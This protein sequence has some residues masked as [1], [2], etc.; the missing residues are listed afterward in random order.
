MQIHDW[1]NALATNPADFKANFIKK[2]S[3]GSVTEGKI[4]D[5]I[6]IIGRS[7]LNQLE[8]YLP[9]PV[10]EMLK[11][12]LKM[13]SIRFEKIV[14]TALKDSVEHT[15]LDL[16]GLG[17]L[18]KISILEGSK[19][20]EKAIKEMAKYLLSL[21]MP[22]H[23]SLCW[24]CDLIEPIKLCM[25]NYR[26][27]LIN[28]VTSLFQLTLLQ[29]NRQPFR[30]TLKQ[31]QILSRIPAIKGHGIVISFIQLLSA[32]SVNSEEGA[33]IE[34]E[35]KTNL[36][37]NKLLVPE[38]KKT[39]NK[40]CN[41]SF[42]NF[43]VNHT[44]FIL[45][46]HR[47][48]ILPLTSIKE[49][50]AK[51]F[52][53]S[54][55]DQQHA[56]FYIDYLDCLIIKEKQNFPFKKA[57]AL[58][59]SLVSNRTTFLYS[60]LHA[61]LHFFHCLAKFPFEKED[62]PAIFESIHA[63]ETKEREDYDTWI[64][65]KISRKPFQFNSKFISYVK[66]KGFPL[67]EIGRNILK[68]CMTVYKANSDNIPFIS[69]KEQIEFSQN[70]KEIFGIEEP[71]EIAID[72]LLFQSTTPAA[73][74]IFNDLV[75]I[76]LKI[77]TEYLDTLAIPSELYH[78][79]TEKSSSLLEAIETNS[80]N[81][82]N[83]NEER[84][85]YYP[86]RMI[87]FSSL[88]HFAV[89]PRQFSFFSNLM[90][91]EIIREKFRFKSGE[92]LQN[93]LEL[94]NRGLPDGPARF[95]YWDIDSSGRACFNVSL[96]NSLRRPESACIFRIPLLVSLEKMWLP[97]FLML[98]ANFID[99]FGNESLTEE[100]EGK[101]KEI[102]PNRFTPP[103][104]CLLMEGA[105]FEI[106]D[107]FLSHF[108]HLEKLWKDNE[109]LFYDT[110]LL[111]VK[112][113]LY[114]FIQSFRSAYKKCFYLVLSQNSLKS[115]I[116]FSKNEHIRILNLGQKQDLEMINL[117]FNQIYQKMSEMGWIALDF[118]FKEMLGK[119]IFFVRI[120]RP[121]HEGLI[122]I[123][124]EIYDENLSKGITVFYE[125]FKDVQH[126]L[127]LMHWQLKVVGFKDLV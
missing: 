25:D 74:T 51:L 18:Y 95:C 61:S 126:F 48:S 104:E 76:R 49:E 80:S 31:E 114:L 53:Q 50:L 79:L 11:E 45:F 9:A 19:I 14:M 15:P 52:S 35:L 65:E 30:L 115:E 94:I 101:V 4:K 60:F 24:K 63:L 105:A 54:I 125:S 5:L 55:F 64:Y 62:A 46:H 37:F 77:I 72:L 43:F 83:S 57:L 38:N 10:M 120:N 42:L 70:T 17:K 113:A 34:E 36:Y 87:Q 12:K 13:Q 85:I 111:E 58:L 93:R 108:P 26:T 16:E 73:I 98:L 7:N 102:T 106:F 107:A 71:L 20:Q 22:Y 117:F 40:R 123:D 3:N 122:N 68:Y 124:L 47:D 69:Q 112:E 88:F 67:K 59:R 82:I 84:F 75:Q 33:A 78:L 121:T 118:T 44:F 109:E 86:Y 1:F 56:L 97:A 29:E 23:E 21:S 66:E 39:V 8:A 103:D 41:I 119:Y 32:W 28:E 27:E 2:F 91:L 99:S 127:S 100:E 90:P 6:E 116:S 89:Y 110:S 92:Q 81:R 96:L